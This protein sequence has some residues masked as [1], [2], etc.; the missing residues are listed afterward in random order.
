[1]WCKVSVLLLLFLLFLLF[2]AV[3]AAAVV[4]VE[5]FVFGGAHCLIV[6]TSLFHSSFFLY[7][8]ISQG[9]VYSTSVAL[10]KSLTTEERQS[11]QIF[12]AVNRIREISHSVALAVIRQAHSE[13]LANPAKLKGVDLDDE[14]QFATWVSSKMYDPVY[15]PISSR[16]GP[17]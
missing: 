6:F 3:V 8:Y 4:V 7:R 13:G 17:R 9:I 12:P 1:M 2:A 5:V 10:A 11:G 14:E 16:T 15:V